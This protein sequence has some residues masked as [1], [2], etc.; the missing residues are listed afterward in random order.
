MAASGLLAA[1]AATQAAMLTFH[2]RALSEL[3]LLQAT[4]LSMVSNSVTSAALGRAVFGEDLTTQTLLG[5]GLLLAGSWLI[6]GARRDEGAGR[7]E[8]RREGRKRD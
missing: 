5:A 6:A 7:G 4:T 2:N 8:G 1:Y 3:T